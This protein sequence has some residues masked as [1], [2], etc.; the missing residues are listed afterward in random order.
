MERMEAQLLV[1][2]LLLLLALALLGWWRAHTRVGRAN[3]RRLRRAQTGEVGAERLLTRQGYRILQRQ[4]HTPWSFFLDGEPV[5]VVSRADLLVE[6]RGLRYVAEV[7]TGSRARNPKAPA[8][9]RQLL[10]YL[11]VYP[12]DG[13][14]LVDMDARA[15]REVRF[16]SRPG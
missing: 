5:E 14:L 6:R 16:P 8:T 11:M 3:L 2:A 10:E 15:V 13:V 1:L 7:K 12:V 9:R 4:C